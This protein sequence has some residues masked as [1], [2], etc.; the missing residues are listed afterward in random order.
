MKPPCPPLDA[1][2]Q[3]DPP[4]FVADHLASC[5]GCR[6][7]A[8][9]HAVRDASEH[10]TSM[11]ESTCAR[12][13]P[14]IA[15]MIDGTLDATSSAALVE[16]LTRC[17]SCNEVAASLS[18]VRDELQHLPEPAP[19][20]MRR[21]SPSAWLV[22]K[23]PWAWAAQIGAVAAL[24]MAAGYAFA[25]RSYPPVIVAP[26]LAR[27]TS[28]SAS[29]NP[30]TA[31]PTLS[32]S[33]EP[34][35]ALA[36]STSPP[37]GYLSVNCVPHCDRVIVDGKLVGRS[38]AVRLAVAEGKHVIIGKSERRSKRTTVN[39]TRGMVSSLTL[40]LEP[41]GS[42]DSTNGEGR[43]SVVCTPYCD[44]IL[45]D[46]ADVGASPL[47]N[48]PVR[49]GSRRFEFRRGEIKKSRTVD[50]RAGTVFPIHVMMESAAEGGYGYLTV[51]CSE[52]CEHVLIDGVD[53]G[54]SPI[55]RHRVKAGVHELTLVRGGER[56]HQRVSVP[57]GKVVPI[58][59][60]MPGR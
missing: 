21:R 53:V 39:V 16:H 31:T 13:E 2:T 12:F 28:H 17:T 34:R 25:V 5:N 26:D 59:V 32:Q 52:P 60:E 35:A 36:D 8:A 33:V 22:P 18:L 14:A 40:H 45:I 11:P 56:K 49:A 27:S 48:H 58:R 3:P 29:P 37:T 30:A 54:V 20:V 23:S 4:A 7:I 15:A 50:V 43:V 47:V 38:P 51:V 1:L 44:R 9:L 55:V 10:V 42:N 6:A 24:A 41:D 57:E 19:A 46:G